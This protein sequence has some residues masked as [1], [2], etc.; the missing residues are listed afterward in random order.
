MKIHQDHIDRLADRA[1][2]LEAHE[3]HAQALCGD[4]VPGSVRHGEMLE[5]R[6]IRVA[7]ACLAGEVAA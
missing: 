3:A 4:C 6:S 2:R 7:L 1:T 5:A